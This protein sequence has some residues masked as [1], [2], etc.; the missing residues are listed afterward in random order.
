MKRTK[1]VLALLACIL[2]ALG[3]GRLSAQVVD[4]EIDPDAITVAQGD[5]VAFTLSLTNTTEEMQQVRISA[6]F[7]TPEGGVFELTRTRPIWL[8]PYFDISLEP[9]IFVPPAAPLGDYILTVAVTDVDDEP[10]DSDSIVVT[11]IEGDGYVDV[12]GGAWKIRGL[13]E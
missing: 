5:F 11:I 12:S 3:A 9:E 8:P 13:T 4:I 7:E 6:T 1:N 2:L 10:I